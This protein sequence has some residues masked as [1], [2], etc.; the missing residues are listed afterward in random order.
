[1]ADIDKVYNKR[2]LEKSLGFSQSVLAGPFLF[3]SGCVSW[4]AEGNPLHVGNLEAQVDTVYAEI[5]ETLKV[6]GLDPNDV[7][8][9]TIYCRDIEALM[10]ANARRL[11]FYRLATPPASTWVQVER[12]AHPDF[13]L[14]V[15]VIAFR[16]R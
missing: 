2:N 11:R 14:E 16:N 10:A 15:E 12:L 3:L 6:R 4:D 1:M 8:K 7:V 9:E 5:E 13:L